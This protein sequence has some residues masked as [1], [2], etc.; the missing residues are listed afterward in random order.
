MKKTVSK[1]HFKP[2]ALQYF[3]EI[4]ESGQELIITDRSKPVIKIVPFTKEPQ[5][6]L[7]EL[8]NSVISYEDPLEPV[9]EEDWESLQ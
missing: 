7:K 9:A 5:E 2:R 8:R 6:V 1:S 3:R 4:Q